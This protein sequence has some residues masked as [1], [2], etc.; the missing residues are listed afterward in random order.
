MEPRRSSDIDLWTLTIAALASAVAAYVTSKLW[1]DGT[2]V[3]AAL[4]PVIVALVKEGLNRP[5]ERVSTIRER[6]TGEQPAVSIHG[7]RKW[8]KV[9]L[10]SGLAAF[11]LVV[12]VFTLP[13]LVA[14]KSIGRSDDSATTFFG[15]TQRT[16]SPKR[17]TRPNATATPTASPKEEAT[18]TATATPEATETREPTATPTAAPAT[19]TA[20]V[21]ATP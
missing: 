11:A 3:S 2:L 21:T 20:T 15:G 7:P 18:P 19:P 14:G 1:P 17:S 8:W 4:F 10:V 9:A 5:V 6:R 13:E 12:A 16:K